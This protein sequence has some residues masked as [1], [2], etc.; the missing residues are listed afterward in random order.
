M[1]P[2]HPKYYPFYAKCVELEIPIQIQVRYCLIYI[3]DR[4]PFR[5]VGR[6]ILLD[7]IACDFPELKIIGIHTGW[8]WIEEMISVARKHPNVDIGT[9][10]HAPKYWKPE[11]VQY[12]NSWGRDKVI[13]GTDF[14]VVE[15]ER[16]MKEIKGM[17]LRPEAKRKLLRDNARR[18]Y[19]LTS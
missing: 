8:P 10:A 9:D 4:P 19:N 2:D 13:F 15:M 14:P 12:L 3:K 5:S 17:R 6:P 11:L 1:E 16:A 7:T 18:V